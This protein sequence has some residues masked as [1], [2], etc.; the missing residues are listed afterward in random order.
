MHE[1]VVLHSRTQQNTVITTIVTNDVESLL[2]CMN[3]N[4]VSTIIVLCIYVF[5]TH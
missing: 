2:L 4:Q 1:G 5:A 3:H